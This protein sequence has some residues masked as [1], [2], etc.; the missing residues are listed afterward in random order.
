MKSADIAVVAI[1]APGAAL[2]ARIAA[3]LSG[4]EVHGRAGRVERADVFFADTPGHVRALFAE[5]RAVVGICAAGILVRAVAPLLADKLE[6]PP[7]LAVSSDGSSV[8]PL[9]GGHRGANGLARRIATALGA[10][11]AI[12]TAGDAIL[13]LGLDDP[14]AGWRV[15]NPAMVAPVTAALLAGEP[16]AVEGLE[17]AG[18]SAWADGLRRLAG[19]PT[20]RPGLV[21]TDRTVSAGPDL[22][23]HPPLLALG[24][25][26]E[27]GADPEEVVALARATLA[28]AGLAEAAVACVASLDLKTD[29]P[30]VAA[31]AAALEV[32]ARF[33]GAADL[34]AETPRLLN[35]SDEVYRAVGCHGVAEAAA[36]AAVGATGAL[37]VGKTRSGRATCA[38]ARATA[39]LDPSRI[40]RQRGHLFVVGI[41]PGG[42]RWRTQEAGRAVA[43]AEDLVGYGPYLDLLGEA[44]DGKTLHRGTLGA[45]TERARLALDLAAAGRAVALVC[46]GDAG[47]YALAAL[48]MELRDREDRAEW[49]R[50][51]LE[52]VPGISAMQMAA[53]RAGAPLGH[54]FC[55]ISLS[56]LLTPWQVIEARLRAAAAGD[57]VTA[58]Y[59]PA[60]DRRRGQ[61]AAARDILLSAR[62]PQTPVVLARNL[63]RAGEQV[64]IDTLASFD[65]AAVDMLTIVL[66]GSSQSRLVE[67]GG[68][69][70]VYTPRGYDTAQ[71]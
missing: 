60:S 52:M 26:C 58:L 62:P 50:I 41:G 61:L 37:V 65:P 47:I 22:V 43:L 49:N 18:D 24:V 2:A 33:F 25:G 68:R 64:E 48:V 13:G 32:P 36:L 45:E 15:A 17:Q 54:D 67:Q 3:A 9:L 44:A 1:N 6:E 30:A 14:P 40:G 16:L 5:G 20:G 57:F 4:A 53:A 29:E 59:N 69:R 12:T 10:Q 34:E 38:V 39:P 56:D 35:P 70:W 71:R 21:I 8:V 27:R 66:V 63:G 11:A 55:A 28:K 42:A 19:A 46:S 31:L 51:A 23:L 7:L